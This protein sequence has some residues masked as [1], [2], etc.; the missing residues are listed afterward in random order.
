MTILK[1][2]S[3]NADMKKYLSTKYY[4]YDEI[5]DLDGKPRHYDYNSNELLNKSGL[6]FEIII[7]KTGYLDEA[8]AGLAMIVER[9][10]DNKKFIIITMG[11]P[12][13]NNRF[14]EPERLARWAMNE[15]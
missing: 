4:E 11:N 12:D 3:V 15:F 1:N 7:S 6:P 13:Y 2:I 8:G 10:T 9:K 14:A 5:K